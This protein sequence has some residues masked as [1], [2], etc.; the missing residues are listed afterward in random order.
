MKL[1]KVPA[2][3]TPKAFCELVIEEAAKRWET[4]KDTVAELKI[5]TKTWMTILKK[6]APDLS[7]HYDRR[8]TSAWI[9]IITQICTILD[10]DLQVCLE[11]CGLPMSEHAV[12][13][14]LTRVSLGI[15][16]L[17]QKDLEALLRIVTELK[18][19]I[20]ISFAFQ[21]LEL[22]RKNTEGQD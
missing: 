16:E 17:T 19:P 1:Q 8:K 5:S 20:P 11:S 21:Y 4:I 12:Q 13:R 9:R 18:Q 10:L 15:T 7:K 14:G 2:E 3:Q 22:F 6:Q